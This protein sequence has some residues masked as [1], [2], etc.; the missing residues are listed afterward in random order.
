MVSTWV[1]PTSKHG[2]GGVMV[3]GCYAGHCC[4]VLKI[5]GMATTAFCELPGNTQYLVIKY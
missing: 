4:D 2:G 1:V 5:Q 3:W